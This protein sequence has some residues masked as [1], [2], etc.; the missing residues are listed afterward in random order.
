MSFSNVI[1]LESLPGEKQNSKRWMSQQP[2][3]AR[4]LKLQLAAVPL[5]TRQGIF[6]PLFHYI[7]Y[8]RH[9]QANQKE[10]SSS[11]VQLKQYGSMY[12]SVHQTHWFL[13]A[14]IHICTFLHNIKARLALRGDCTGHLHNMIWSMSLFKIIPPWLS[15]IILEY[16]LSEFL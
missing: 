2:L 9:S 16:P 3:D 1:H 5:L 4:L 13:S 6:P 10:I 11:Q 15:I 7:S 14:N 8:Q 12:R